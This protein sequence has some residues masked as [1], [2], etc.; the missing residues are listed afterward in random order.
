MAIPIGILPPGTPYV[1][2]VT[3][4]P[5]SLGKGGGLDTEDIRLLLLGEIASSL[6]LLQG[7]PSVP[8]VPSLPV[9]EGTV[10]AQVPRV[11]PVAVN[12]PLHWSEVDFLVVMLMIPASPSVL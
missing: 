9:I 2:P 7:P 3:A 6:D 11:L 1:S 10:E 8:V 12:N 5:F 4:P